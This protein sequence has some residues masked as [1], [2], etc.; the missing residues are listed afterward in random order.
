MCSAIP[1]YVPCNVPSTLM[2]AHIGQ[3]YVGTPHFGNMDDTNQL[4]HKCSSTSATMYNDAEHGCPCA[5]GCLPRTLPATPQPS[6]CALEGRVQQRS[7]A[8]A[9]RRLCTALWPTVAHACE[10]GQLC[11]PLGVM[12]HIHSSCDTHVAHACEVQHA[13][14]GRGP[15]RQQGHALVNACMQAG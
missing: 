2:Y 10:H 13:P 14:S 12:G 1:W 15:G 6:H 3:K 5:P 8:A 7:G 9:M 11:L 4:R